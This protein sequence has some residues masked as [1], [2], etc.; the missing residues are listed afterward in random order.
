MPEQQGVMKLPIGFIIFLIGLGGVLFKEFFTKRR[1]KNNSKMGD[2]I[3]YGFNTSQNIASGS[4]SELWRFIV[5]SKSKLILTKFGNYINEPDAWGL[6]IWR[7]K[8]NGVGV[9][10]YSRIED[11][12]GYPSSLVSLDQVEARGGD[13]FVIEATNDYGDVVKVGIVLKYQLCGVD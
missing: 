6:I 9:Y 8:R 1:A 3:K 4:T 13:L 2:V 12:L 10:P 5:P 11:Q 7:F